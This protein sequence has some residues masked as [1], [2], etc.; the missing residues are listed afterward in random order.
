MI[1][2]NAEQQGENVVISFINYGNP[3]P[4]Q[5]LDRIFEKFFRLDPSNSSITGGSGLGLAIAREIVEAHGGTII[6]QSSEKY[7]VFAVTIS[8]SGVENSQIEH[9]S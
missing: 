8:V 2:I 4:S 5:Q 7:T 1:K 6:A 9:S 3:I